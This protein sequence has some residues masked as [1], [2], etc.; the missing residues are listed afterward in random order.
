MKAELLTSSTSINEEHI[1]V[2]K[3]FLIHSGSRG[4]ADHGWTP[5]LASLLHLQKLMLIESAEAV[6]PIFGL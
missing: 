2:S 6:T 5:L 1:D 4:R 3:G